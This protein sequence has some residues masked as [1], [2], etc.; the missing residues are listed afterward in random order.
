MTRISAGLKHG[1]ILRGF[2]LVRCHRRC[3]SPLQRRGFG[4]RLR[5]EP[6]RLK[7]RATKQ[8]PRLRI[9]TEP[10]RFWLSR[11]ERKYLFVRALSGPWIFARAGESQQ[12]LVFVLGGG[13]LARPH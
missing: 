8:G 4:C 13:F 6:P 10:D 11:G 12:R 7:T 1:G 9:S 2:L 3:S 5:R